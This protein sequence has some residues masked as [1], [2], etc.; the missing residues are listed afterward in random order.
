M[1]SC[2]DRG[3]VVD[4]GAA[5]REVG[6]NSVR[7][8][9]SVSHGQLLVLAL[10]PRRRASSSPLVCSSEPGQAQDNPTIL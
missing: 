3:E 9:Q 10:C 2:K 6:D 5:G 8:R 1:T 7:L 4:A